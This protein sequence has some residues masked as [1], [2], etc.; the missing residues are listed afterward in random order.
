MLSRRGF[1]ASLL[2][3]PLLAAMPERVAVLTFDDGVVSHATYVGPRLKEL[4]YPATFFVCE[5]PPDFAD[6]TKYMTW[7]QIRGL[8]EQ[9]FE[10]GSHTW[11]HTHVDKVDA[12]GLYK[13]LAWVEDK[14]HSLGIP[15]PVSFAYPAYGT[16]PKAVAVLKERGYRFARTGGKPE[17]V[18]PYDPAK[19]DPLLMPSFT[20]G[21][22][23]TPVMDGL[24]QARRG[25]VIVIT[26]H[27][28]PDTAHPWV[29]TPRDVFEGYLSYLRE[30]QFTVLAMR[31]LAKFL[32]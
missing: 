13:E 30:K 6:K 24:A 16:N 18:H 27:G 10:I 7:E 29:T 8:H 25:Q 21:E 32:E 19:D 2:A 3:A 23:K 20:S 12:A 31:D 22:D 17:F 28:V 11:H 1:T 26:V 4:G 14:F 15:K 9:G 5:F